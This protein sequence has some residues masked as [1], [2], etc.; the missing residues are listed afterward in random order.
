MLESQG[1]SQREIAE[2]IGVSDQ[3]VSNI[4]LGKSSPGPKFLKGLGIVRKW[5]YELTG[6]GLLAEIQAT[7]PKKRVYIRKKAFNPLDNTH[8]KRA[9]GRTVGKEAN[10]APEISSAPFH[11]GAAD[12]GP[13]SL[14]RIKV[15]QRHKVNPG[16]TWEAF[17]RETSPAPGNVDQAWEVFCKDAAARI[18]QEAPPAL[19]PAPAPVVAPEPARELY[20]HLKPVQRG[21]DHRRKPALG[22]L[23]QLVVPDMP[24]AK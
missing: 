24:E 22:E 5:S 14:E 4:A 15:A 3:S 19:E 11:P 21:I 17:K 12:H 1:F 23:P 10:S 18:A 16:Q 7:M 2:R 8:G 20:A 9:H 13:L 6:D